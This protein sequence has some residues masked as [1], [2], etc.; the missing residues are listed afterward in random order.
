MQDNEV[1]IRQ[2]KFRVIVLYLTGDVLKVYRTGTEKRGEGWT[3]CRSHVHT[4]KSWQHSLKAMLMPG[5]VKKN[6]YS[7]ICCKK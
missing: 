1:H 4:D 6:D 3:R 5:L 2:V 7:K